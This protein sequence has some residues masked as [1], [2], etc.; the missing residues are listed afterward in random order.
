MSTGNSPLQSYVTLGVGDEIFAVSVQ[1]VR[2]ILDYIAPS[3]LPHAPSFM[4]GMID[5][6]GATVPLIDLRMKLGL[7]PA[8]INDTSRILVLELSLNDKQLLLGLLTDQVYEVV[9]MATS[10]LESTP[11][12]GYRWRSEYI[13]AI[14]RLNN[15]FVVIFDLERLFSSD[16]IALIQPSL[17]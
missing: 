16:E 8:T 7:A 11:E 10:E 15:K 5:V 9:E 13:R 6:R 4:L 3:A 17:S 12:V 1:N 14:G 2:E